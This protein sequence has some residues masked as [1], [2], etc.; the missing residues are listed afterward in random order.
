VQEA[1]FKYKTSTQKYEW[2]PFLHKGSVFF[3]SAQR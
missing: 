1:N 3:F 2:D